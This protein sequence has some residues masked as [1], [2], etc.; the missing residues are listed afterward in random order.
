M[1]HKRYIFTCG[2]IFFFQ[3]NGNVNVYERER[4]EKGEI[5]FRIYVLWMFFCSL[6]E[7]NFYSNL[8]MWRDT[9]KKWKKLVCRYK[10]NFGVIRVNNI[11]KYA[12]NT[13]RRAINF[14]F[15][16]GNFAIFVHLTSLCFLVCCMM[17]CIAKIEWKIEIYLDFF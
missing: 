12:L 17:W 16:C 9:K 13:S 7:E 11:E 14:C 5:C 3:S 4:S 8:S 10:A 6:R 2:I 15:C 1:Q